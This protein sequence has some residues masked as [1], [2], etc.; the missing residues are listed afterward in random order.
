MV[1]KLHF[2]GATQG[3]NDNNYYHY[4]VA[5]HATYMYT[6]I[7]IPLYVVKTK[8]SLVV[9]GGGGGGEEEAVCN[10]HGLLVGHV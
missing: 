9:G 4:I 3:H 1:L 10:L 5:V 2:L 7:F 8:V 6:H